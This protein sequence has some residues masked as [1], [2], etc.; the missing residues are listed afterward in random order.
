MKFVH[1]L[2]EGI[3]DNNHFFL[4]FQVLKVVVRLIVNCN[5][6]VKNKLNCRRLSTKLPKNTRHHMVELSERFF[7]I[8]LLQ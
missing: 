5:L 8:R 4:R 1:G 2:I 7:L 3:C 6:S